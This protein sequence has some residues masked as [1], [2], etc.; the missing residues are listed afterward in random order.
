MLQVI[1]SLNGSDSQLYSSKCE[2]RVF[3]LKE[4]SSNLTC[5]QSDFYLEKLKHKDTGKCSFRGCFSVNHISPI[6]DPNAQTSLGRDSTKRNVL[7]C[8]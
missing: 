6:T 5:L 3:Y 2:R 4:F 1:D 8:A 7:A